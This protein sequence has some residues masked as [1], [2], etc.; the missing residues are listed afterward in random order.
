MKNKLNKQIKKLLQNYHKKFDC[1][2]NRKKVK[3]DTYE[4]YVTTIE[5][6][7]FQYVISKKN[8][9]FYIN[10]KIPNDSRYPKWYNNKYA[11]P[12]IE[13]KFANAN[14]LKEAKNIILNDKEI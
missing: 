2:G 11:A 1:F 10:K 14:S 4:W 7:N 9:F 6:N 12:F 3:K 13:I 8:N 5:N